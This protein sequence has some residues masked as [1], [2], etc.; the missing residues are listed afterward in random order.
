M[1]IAF[2]GE[3]IQSVQAS[4]FQTLVTSYYFLDILINFNT[5]YNKEGQYFD[6]RKQIAVN[7]LQL[8]FWID[9]LTTVPYQDIMESLSSAEGNSFI[10][11][12]R[13]LKLLR[14]IR[15]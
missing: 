5:G 11:I 7:Y 8:W 12:L 13:F 10:K 9:L 15:Y 2:D 6:D 3:I 4:M 1:Q 14:L